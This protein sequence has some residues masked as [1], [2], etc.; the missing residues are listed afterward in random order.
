MHVRSEDTRQPLPLLFSGRPEVVSPCTALPPSFF[1]RFSLPWLSRVLEFFV[2]RPAR[3]FNPPHSASR[4]PCSSH[5]HRLFFHTYIFQHF[6]CPVHLIPER[7]VWLRLSACCTY[8]KPCH[9]KRHPAAADVDLI[10]PHLCLADHHPWFI[11]LPNRKI[12][13][14]PSLTF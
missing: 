9:Q 13:L 2:P 8:I 1:A 12:R 11:W 3:H 6:H 10:P 4:R 5:C 14:D 7:D